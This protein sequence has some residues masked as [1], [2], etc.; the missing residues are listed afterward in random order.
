MNF[1]KQ[2]PVVMNIVNQIHR[3]KKLH[4]FFDIMLIRSKYMMIFSGFMA[5]DAKFRRSLEN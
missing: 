5:C 3:N 4:A 1:P 2:T